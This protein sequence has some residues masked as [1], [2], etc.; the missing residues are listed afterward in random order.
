ME[1]SC[2]EYTI[3]I[4]YWDWC[5]YK[6]SSKPDNTALDWQTKHDQ[7][8]AEIKVEEHFGP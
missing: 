3:F 8:W 6:D 1:G 4:G 2:G 5:L 7:L